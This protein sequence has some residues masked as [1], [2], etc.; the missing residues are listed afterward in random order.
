MKR[1]PN[2]VN[3]LME[4]IFV[5]AMRPFEWGSFDCALAACDLWEV[6][7]GIDPAGDLRRYRTRAGAT[8]VLATEAPDVLAD[9]R[10]ERVA[11]RMAGEVGMI[12][13]PAPYAQRGFIVLVSGSPEITLGG[14][15][16]LGVVDLYGTGILV[17]HLDGGWATLPLTRARL[18]W[19]V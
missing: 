9:R 18:A 10:L 3:L 5:R 1:Y 2:W 14:T 19:G 7:T 11:E 8:R 12:A 4:A 13:Y 17:P 16:A 15:D 6:Q